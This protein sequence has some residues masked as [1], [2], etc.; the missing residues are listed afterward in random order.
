M[1]GIRDAEEFPDPYLP[2]FPGVSLLTALL[3]RDRSAADLSFAL[4]PP[5]IHHETSD[6]LRDQRASPPG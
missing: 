3:A 4:K 6:E 5:S 1:V 2:P